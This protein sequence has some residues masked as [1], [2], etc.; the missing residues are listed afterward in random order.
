MVVGEQCSHTEIVGWV[1]S[2]DRTAPS[3]GGACRLCNTLQPELQQ[4]DLRATLRMSYILAFED[5][6]GVLASSNIT[7]LDR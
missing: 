5:S 3:T 4:S 1:H 7:N 2:L 6:L